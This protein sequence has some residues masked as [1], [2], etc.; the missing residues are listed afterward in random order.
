M[1]SIILVLSAQWAGS[2]GAQADDM[3]K[4]EAEFQAW[5]AS[6]AQALQDDFGQLRYYR[7]ANSAIPSPDPGQGR[8]VFFGD[9]I[10]EGWPLGVYFPG[11]PYIN[12]GI[13]AQTTSQMLIRFRQDAVA[14]KPRVI[15]I[16]A[17]ANDLNGN[18]GVIS[19]EDIESNF[20]AM[21]EIARGNGIRVIFSSLLPPPHEETPQSRY[22]L[23]KHPPEK[24]AALNGWLQGYSAAN[25]LRF[26]DYFAAMNDGSGLIRRELSEDGVHPTAAGYSVMAVVAQAAIDSA[27][28][29][30]TT[31]AEPR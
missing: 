31:L 11:K 15:V 16:L 28:R 19:I 26:V 3:A 13:S 27:L 2:A 21:A 17:G 18:T 7:D 1:K 12:R 30:E 4:F 20:A 5:R 9:S 14:L 29:A 25:G 24:T 6:R 8:V 22:N 10:T 23:H